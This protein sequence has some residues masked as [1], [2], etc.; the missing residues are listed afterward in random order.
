M[1]SRA[2]VKMF[3]GTEMSGEEERNPS[4][5]SQVFLKHLEGTG[6]F[7]QIKDLEKNLRAIA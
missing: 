4:D 1:L 7:Q 3:L 2:T 6:F 5:T